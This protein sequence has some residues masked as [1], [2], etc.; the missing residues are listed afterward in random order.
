MNPGFFFG[1]KCIQLTTYSIEPT[2]D[3]VRFAM[4]GAFEQTMLHEV[5][6]AVFLRKLIA[7][8]CADHNATMRHF[9]RH[10]LMYN[11][12][13]VAQFEYDRFYNGT[14]HAWYITEQKPSAKAD[15]FC[16]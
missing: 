16:K 14:I 5:R 4:C 10:G 6:K 12:N 2:H 15:G 9:A 1:R 8:T 7:R 11:S 3:V 13:S